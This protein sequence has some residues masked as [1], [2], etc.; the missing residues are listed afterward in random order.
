MKIIIL[1]ALLFVT[2]IASAQNLKGELSN[3]TRLTNNNAKY[4][5]PRWS[6]DGAYIAFTNYGYNNLY[7]MGANGENMHRIS[8]AAGVGFMYQWS[9]DSKEILVRDLRYE[10]TFTGKKRSQAAWA[11]SLNGTKTRLTE[12]VTRMNPAVWSYSRLGNVNIICHEAKCIDRQR[13]ALSKSLGDKK[14]SLLANN[15][16]AMVDQDGLHIIYPNGK[17]TK[18]NN[19][20]AFCP[21]VSPDG[22]QVVFN[23]KN[24]ICI[25]NIDGTGKRILARGFNPTWANNNQIIYERSTD[26]GHEY[27]SSDLYLINA[28]GTG[29]LAL[30]KTPDMMEMCPSISPDGKKLVFT[31]YTDGQIYV[32]NIK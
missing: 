4:E 16:N 23:E 5:N 14:I 24:N 1:T 7:V 18:I 30:T 29:A 26:N 9:A 3:V 20:P 11:V 31:S 13:Q 28:D 21:A 10:N 12:D 22:K 27:T 2:G 17:K 25:I 19:A 15:V 32:A 8:D 6:P